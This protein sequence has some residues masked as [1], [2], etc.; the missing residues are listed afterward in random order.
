MKINKAKIIVI[1]GVLVLSI[2]AGLFIRIFLKGPQLKS[3]QTLAPGK[4]P[5]GVSTFKKSASEFPPTI[6]ELEGLNIPVLRIPRPNIKISQKKSLPS[7]ATPFFD[8]INKAAEKILMPSSAPV[9]NISTKTSAGIILNL[10]KD[11]FH[12]LYPD[13]F[14]ASLINAQNLS[15]KE[16]DPNYEPILKIETDAQVR[17]IEEK[18][19]ATLLSAN[20]IPKEKAEQFIT[21]IRFTLPELQ[22]IDLQKHNSSVFYKSLLFPEFVNAV[23]ERTEPEKTAPKNLFLAGLME[24]L[25]GAL[26][27]KAQAFCG[28]CTSIPECFQ[29]GA[30]PPGVAGSELFYPSCYCTGCLTELGCLSANNGQAAIYDQTTGICGVGTGGS[31]SGGAGIPGI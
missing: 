4:L 20:M 27:H 17:F 9:Q 5:D 24:Q 7:V 15:I 10:T 2:L 8:N 29:E 19:V 18:I 31:G 14:I 6:K 13:N 16:L 22:L 28:T 11:Q 21:T 25:R 1:F 23:V 12:F 26:A 3:E 30:A